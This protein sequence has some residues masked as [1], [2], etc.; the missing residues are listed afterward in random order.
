MDLSGLKN[1]QAFIDKVN[2]ADI[3]KEKRYLVYKS[4]NGQVHTLIEYGEHSDGEGKQKRDELKRFE[5]NYYD[6]IDFKLLKLLYPLEEVK[7]EKA[8]VNP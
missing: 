7:D 1:S 4:W 2:N 3:F 6:P 8:A 5:L